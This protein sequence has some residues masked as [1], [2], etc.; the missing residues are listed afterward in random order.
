MFFKKRLLL[1]LS[2]IIN[3]SFLFWY[4]TDFKITQWGNIDLTTSNFI[5]SY[6][7]TKK[8]IFW[9]ELLNRINKIKDSDLKIFFIQKYTEII[10]VNQWWSPIRTQ[11][12]QALDMAQNIYTKNQEWGK[13]EKISKEYININPSQTLGWFKLGLAQEKQGKENEAIESYYQVLSQEADN[14]ETIIQLGN[15]LIQ[16]G[17]FYSVKNIILQ[18][19]KAAKTKQTKI[20]I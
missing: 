9:S 2:I 12:N 16:K 10:P 19:N 17:D 18:N 6:Y 1:A 15:L 4:F 20:N 8:N 14:I 11:K 13:L 5:E 3:F 7:W